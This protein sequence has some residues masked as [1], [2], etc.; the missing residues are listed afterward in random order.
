MQMFRKCRLD[1]KRKFNF[2]F[3][4]KKLRGKIILEIF[5]SPETGRC[6]VFFLFVPFNSRLILRHKTHREFFFLGVSHLLYHPNSPN[7]PPTTN[8]FILKQQNS[9]VLTWHHLNTHTHTP[10]KKVDV[11]NFPPPPTLYFI[12]F[13]K[14]FSMKK[15]FNKTN[16][17]R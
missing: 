17:V 6:T 12:F 2:K 16:G 1:R 11:T 3:C 10:E 4:L 5:C 9:L 7:S 13:S 8:K 14:N 15:K